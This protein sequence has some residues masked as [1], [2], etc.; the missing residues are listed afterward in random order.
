VT[1]TG[2]KLLD[3]VWRKGSDNTVVMQH[4]EGGP[5]NFLAI[6]HYNSWQDLQ[7][8]RLRICQNRHGKGR[9]SQ[10]RQFG[11]YHIDTLA[12]RISPK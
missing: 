4:I 6:D 9:L 10:V 3:F 8:M 12:D 1:K 11:A 2:T 5:W 7:P